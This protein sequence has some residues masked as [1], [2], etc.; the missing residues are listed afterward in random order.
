MTTKRL[1]AQAILNELSNDRL[2]IDFHIDE[3]EVFLRM[4]QEVNQMARASFF[5]NWQV[6]GAYLDNQFITEWSGDNG[7]TVVDVEDQPSYLVLPASYIDLPRNAGIQE[8]WPLEY[9]AY[10]QSVVI[11]SHGDLRLYQ[12]NKAGN[13]QHRL[14]GYPAGVNKFVF[15]EEN[16]GERYSSKFG[17]RLAIRDSSAIAADAPYGIPADK[18]KAL[19]MV[20]VD[21]FRKRIMFGSDKVRDSNTVN[22]G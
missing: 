21:W 20:L 6:S 22:N 11:I 16:V 13:M 1:L 9:G 8:I 4:D 7:I 17:V 5:E 2:N 15:S 18:E 14:H 3:R 12:N 19:V 10:N